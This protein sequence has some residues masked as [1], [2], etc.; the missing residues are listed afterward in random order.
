ML[1]IVIKFWKQD[2]LIN[3]IKKV[4]KLF[5]YDIND[6]LFCTYS[7]PLKWWYICITFKC[8]KFLKINLNDANKLNCL[9]LFTRDGQGDNAP[10]LT[11][12]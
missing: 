12:K 1:S 6:S 8:K 5:F 7:K 3:D 11:V 2:F 9:N 10:D 4:N